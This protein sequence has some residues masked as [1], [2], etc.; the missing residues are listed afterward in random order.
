MKN[1]TTL[2]FLL[3]V[4]PILGQTISPSFSQDAKLLT[5]GDSKRGYEAPTANVLLRVKLET[6]K[7]IVL[8]PEFEYAD[9]KEAYYRYSLNGGYKFGYKKISATPY[10]GYGF[11]EHNGGSRGFSGGLDFSYNISNR[12]TATITNQ[13]TERTDLKGDI[14]KYSIFVGVEYKIHLK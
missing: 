11:I 7:N 14:I 6:K 3:L 2:L 1:L 5:I 12:F 10:I 13:A 9:L 8:F 4:F